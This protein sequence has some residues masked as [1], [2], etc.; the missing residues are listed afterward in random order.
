MNHITDDVSKL[1]VFLQPLKNDWYLL[2]QHL[3]VKKPVLSDVHKLQKEGSTVQM[4]CLLQNWCTEGGTLT[5]LENALLEMDKK[6][7]ISGNKHKA[8]KY[9]FIVMLKVYII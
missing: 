4:K 8:N 1:E 3:Q 7:L 6:D 9:S 5:K 2:G